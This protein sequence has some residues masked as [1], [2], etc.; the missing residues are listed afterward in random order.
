MG[1]IEEAEDVPILSSGLYEA[2]QRPRR[3]VGWAWGFAIVAIL[4]VV[5]GIYAGT[6]R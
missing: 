4:T 5:G 2:R 3:D 6:H 1:R